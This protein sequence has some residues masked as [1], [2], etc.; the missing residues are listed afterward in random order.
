MIDHEATY[1]AQ[2]PLPKKEVLRLKPGTFIEVKWSDAPNTVVMLLERP[3]N[4]PGPVCLRVFD[5]TNSVLTKSLGMMHY[6]IDSDQVV[7]VRG[8]IEVPC[9][10]VL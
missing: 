9:P 10:Q 4:N 7:A 1:K 2:K 5:T 8:M 3:E 6:H